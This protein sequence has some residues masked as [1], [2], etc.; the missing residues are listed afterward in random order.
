[1][2]LNPGEAVHPQKEMSSINPPSSCVLAR[3]GG[4]T[5]ACADSGG[6]RP[7]VSDDF[8]LSN[9]AD[10]GYRGLDCIAENRTFPM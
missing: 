1:V 6:S 10:H 9:P 7:R 5:P 4:W 8:A 3:G 2:F